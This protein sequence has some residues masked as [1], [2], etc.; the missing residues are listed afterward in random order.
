MSRPRLPFPR[1]DW[2]SFHTQ[3]FV[4]KLL[5]CAP[6]LADLSDWPSPDDW[7]VF[8]ERLSAYKNLG[9][10]FT[11]EEKPGQRA[12]RKIAKESL[13]SYERWIFEDAEIPTRAENWHD[14]FNAMIWMNFPEAKKSLHYKALSI[15]KSWPFDP[16]FQKGKRSPLADRLTCFDEGGV[17][18][19]M[20]SGEVRTE[21]EAILCGR[22]DAAKEHFVREHS[23][24][25]TLFGHGILEVLM[26]KRSQGEEPERVNASC[27]ILD[28]SLA[29]L[30]H[31]LKTYLQ[32]FDDKAP[33]H[34]TITVAWL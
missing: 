28:P 9:L 6:D 12:R 11:L 15:Q 30:D 22:D 13:R 31:K 26:K 17:V 7:Q 24:R 23:E 21:V 2:M 18:F 19:E 27:I 10:R 4:Q 14:F 3:A 29:S 33:S 25:F 5:F 34:G 16:D 20:I 32:N 8:G 1:E